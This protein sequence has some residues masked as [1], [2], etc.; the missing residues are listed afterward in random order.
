MVHLLSGWDLATQ[1]LLG[2]F[3]GS[4]ASGFRAVPGNVPHIVAGTASLVAV[5]I[6]LVWAFTSI[7]LT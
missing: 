6:A 3:L 1:A 7:V 2:P 4:N 5:T